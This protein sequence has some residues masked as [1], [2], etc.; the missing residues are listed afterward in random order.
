MPHSKDAAHPSINDTSY[1]T[2]LPPPY[3]EAVSLPKDATETK[4]RGQASTGDKKPSRQPGKCIDW[5]R[6]WSLSA[7]LMAPWSHFSLQVP[8]QQARDKRKAEF[9]QESRR[10]IKQLVEELN[11]KAKT[12]AEKVRADVLAEEERRRR[13]DRWTYEV[14][15]QPEEAQDSE[16]G[17]ASEKH[18]DDEAVEDGFLHELFPQAGI[19]IDPSFAAELA[20]IVERMRPA[21]DE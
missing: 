6:L 3:S 19:D 21:E 13:V 7:G 10:A 15:L 9:R 5:Y 14:V 11:E 20:Q 1:T 8:N 2:D 18:R 4:I 12:D 16:G 17:A